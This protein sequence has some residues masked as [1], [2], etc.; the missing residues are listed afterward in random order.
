MFAAQPRTE[1]QNDAEDAGDNMRAEQRKIVAQR[2]G[3]D[4]RDADATAQGQQAPSSAVHEP[5]VT[6]NRAEKEKKKCKKGNSGDEMQ[7]NEGIVMNGRSRPGV[8]VG[9]CEKK[10]DKQAEETFSR[11]GLC[12]PSVN[13]LSIEFSETLRIRSEDERIEGEIRLQ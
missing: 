6:P 9:C 2:S 7:N 3:K 12:D 13:A 1:K 8:F 4:Q 5:R 11:H 10:Y